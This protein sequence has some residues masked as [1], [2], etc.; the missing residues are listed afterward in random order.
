MFT[1]DSIQNRETD[2]TQN[3]N[4]TFYNS[5]DKEFCTR[6]HYQRRTKSEKMLSFEK[7]FE[8]FFRFFIE[9]FVDSPSSLRVI[10][11]EKLT[12]L[13]PETVNICT[14]KI[15]HICALFSTA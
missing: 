13:A 3:K 15:L 5:T 12:D 9:H 6:W 7:I 4:E 14:G 1:N 8:F 10:H 11:E 2:L